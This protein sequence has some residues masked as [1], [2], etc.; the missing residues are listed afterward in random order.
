MNRSTG[1]AM[2]FCAL[3][4]VAAAP[5]RPISLPAIPMSSAT[6]VGALRTDG[7]LIPFARYRRGSWDAPL[8]RVDEGTPRASLADQASPWFQKGN[9][10]S[11]WRFWSDERDT[12]K[13]LK[14]SGL[15]RVDCLCRKNWGL[16]TNL[17]D[18]VSAKD[19][20]PQTRA[21]ALDSRVP[22]EVWNEVAPA[23]E[24]GGRI[25]TLILPEHEK[26]EQEKSPEIAAEQAEV[27]LDLRRLYRARAPVGSATLYYFE[28]E[29]AYAGGSRISYSQGWVESDGPGGFRLLKLTGGWTASDRKEILEEKPLGVLDMNGRIYV[30]SEEQ[31]WDSLRYR[32]REWGEKGVRSA[33]DVE[34]GSC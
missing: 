34:A 7:V 21:L 9:R 27:R 22:V 4:G 17:R 19:R 1:L 29:K 26:V 13:T 3:G 6:T 33:L 24:E 16:T 2:A 15:V 23:S 20:S 11:F 30:I 12:W 28:A 14:A 18:A 31:G 10:K 5:P 8:S 32:I 25:A